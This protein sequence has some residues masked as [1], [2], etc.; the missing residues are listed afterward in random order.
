MH[1]PV[2]LK[3]MLHYLSPENGKTYLDCTF[4]AGGYTKAILNAAN[5]TVYGIDIDPDVANVASALESTYK[6]R[7]QLLQGNYSDCKDLLQ[8]INVLSV[9]GIVMDLGVSS[10][11]LDIAERGFSFSKTATLDMRMSK[12][13]LSAHEFVN[14]ADEKTLAHVILK[15]G[16][17]RNFKKIASNI[18]K[19][20]LSKPIETTT[21][22]A[23]IV[24][25]SFGRKYSAIDLATK[26]FQAIRIHINDELEHLKQALEA[27]LGLLNEGGRLVV[28]TFHSLEDI[29]VKRFMQRE[30]GARTFSNRYIPEHESQILNKPKLKILTKKAITP[31][32]AEIKDN[33]RARSAK[34]RAALKTKIEQDYA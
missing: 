9:D 12:G 4:G 25:S 7:F 24:R 20:R 28:V 15:F 17:E 33:R 10:M 6:D 8:K 1:T 31:S 29:I 19:A 21:E 3:E 11:Q 18:V 16:E 32:F 2:L 34:L 14:S 27:A 30:S 22:L 26:T 5:T 23:E 13:G